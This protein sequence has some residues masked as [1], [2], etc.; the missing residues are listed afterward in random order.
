MKRW[1]IVFAALLGVLF[2]VEV[3]ARWFVGREFRRL[4]GGKYE[5]RVG[6]VVINPFSG[7]ATANN[8][9]VS[10]DIV[11]INKLRVERPHFRGGVGVRRIVLN[12]RD[13][14]E[15]I[16]YSKGRLT[17]G[18]AR[19]LN[20]DGSL[21][22]EVDSLVVDTAARVATVRRVAMA[23]TYS[24]QDF[25][26]K[27]W[28]HGDWTL[29]SVADVVC[30]GVD[31]K[32]GRI[33]SL[34][35]GGGEIASYKDRNT[36]HNATVK[37][38]YHTVIQR[39]SP[40]IKIRAASFAGLNAIYEELPLK[41]TQAGR[42]TFSGIAG[43]SM[44][45]GKR[46][47]WQAVA[48]VQDTAQ[49]LARGTLP[50]EGNDFE[51]EGSIAECRAVIFNPM[52]TP[53]GGIEIRGG[54]IRRFDF[55]LQGDTVQARAAVSLAW[56]SLT[57]ELFSRNHHDRRLLSA[58]VNDFVLPPASAGAPT[59]ADFTRDPTRSPWSYVWHTIFASIKAG[60]IPK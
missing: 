9:R 60:V 10:P 38:M 58:I 37:P 5:L 30:T 43:Q 25:T 24:K 47:E 59:T 11:N 46:I 35:I 52:A 34:H 26:P 42:I 15:N 28:R 13:T 40:H 17:L 55:A 19:V 23:P 7:T 39:L 14:I 57:V 18:R 56:D 44:A 8:I 4:T 12:R 2:A 36:S 49:L 48:F 31:I 20:E 3:A 1:L 33:D 51:I 27:S 50:L 29:L 32:A 45:A 6:Y 41:G 22:Y 16:L 54:R 21:R 53:L